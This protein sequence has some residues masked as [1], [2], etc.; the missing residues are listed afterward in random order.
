MTLNRAIQYLLSLYIA[1]S[2]ALS[3][4]PVFGQ[5]P[6]TPPPA[7]SAFKTEAPPSPNAGRPAPPPLRT[8]PRT[9]PPP[10]VTTK[11]AVAPAKPAA[12]DKPAQVSTPAAASTPAAPASTA[13]PRC[14][15]AAT[16][17]DYECGRNIPVWIMGESTSLTNV[18]GTPSK[19]DSA[20]LSTVAGGTKITAVCNKSYQD[21][22]SCEEFWKVRIDGVNKPDGTP[23]EVYI[24]STRVQVEAPKSNEPEYDIPSEGSGDGETAPGNGETEAGSSHTEPPCTDCNGT[25]TPP[26]PLP[27]DT[28]P[29]ETK[30]GPPPPVTGPPPTPRPKEQSGPVTYIHPVTSPVTDGFGRRVDPVSG[31][32][33]KMHKGLDYNTI[34]RGDFGLP[35]KASAKGE[36]Y[37]IISS[38]KDWSSPRSRREMSCAG[39]WGN[40]VVIKHPDGKFTR[41]AHLQR[42]AAFS[43]LTKGQQVEQGQEIGCVGSSG[44]STGPHLHFE[45]RLGGPFG[46]AVDPRNYIK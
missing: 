39:G 13:A 17:I 15:G 23:K 18:R 29:G 9:P 10:A 42:C 6:R 40:Q 34:G 25:G 41:Y 1:M 24:S 19:S 11:P 38:C 8:S 20:I 45:M 32:R 7:A 21:P 46:D 22:V 14:N 44:K 27:T 31:Q 37:D 33:G 3:S 30:T 36:I 4:A 2:V 12:V 16:R 5:T 28:A 35:V 26:P 43:F